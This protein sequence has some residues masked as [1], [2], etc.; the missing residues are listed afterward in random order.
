MPCVLAWEDSAKWCICHQ[1]WSSYMATAVGLGTEVRGWPV[2]VRQFMFYCLCVFFCC[3]KLPLLISPVC[4]LVFFLSYG[5][6]TW[7]DLER[8]RERE[9]GGSVCVCV[10]VCV[11]L[12]VCVCVCVW[13]VCVCVCVCVWY[14][15]V[16]ARACVHMHAQVVCVCVRVCVHVIQYYLS[17]TCSVCVGVWVHVCVCVCVCVCARTHVCV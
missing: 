10:C 7:Y 4:V 3:G 6:F 14:V 12:C 16:C 2:Q 11:C 8:E 9:G 1:Q 5:L 13:Y 17:P 15:C